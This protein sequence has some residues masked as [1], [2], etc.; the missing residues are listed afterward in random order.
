VY[1]TADVGSE[2]LEKLSSGERVKSDILHREAPDSTLE[3]LLMLPR[4]NA[5]AQPRR[6]PWLQI[7]EQSVWSRTLND[8][9]QL[10]QRRCKRHPLKTIH[11]VKIGCGSSLPGPHWSVE[12]NSNQRLLHREFPIVLGIV[13]NFG[14]PSLPAC[15]TTTADGKGADESAPSKR[16]LPRTKRTSAARIT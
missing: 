15:H 3:K 13:E 6:H 4:Q 11:L 16:S 2:T 10:F 12:R 9:H 1:T 14:G 8:R 7:V 5:K